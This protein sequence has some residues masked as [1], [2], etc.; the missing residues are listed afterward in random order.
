MD[1]SHRKVYET[2]LKKWANYC[3]ECNGDSQH[4]SQIDHW[5]Q[6]LS[7]EED[8][9]KVQKLMTTEKFLRELRQAELYHNHPIGQTKRSS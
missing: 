1:P 4:L 5:C 6:I 3:F 9:T 2:L 8:D 7:D